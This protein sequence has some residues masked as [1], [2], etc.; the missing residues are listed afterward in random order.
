VSG[1]KVI[2]LSLFARPDHRPGWWDY[3]RKF[4]SSLARAYPVIFPADAGWQV[5]LYHDRNFYHGYYTQAVEL[6]ARGPQKGY[7]KLVYGGEPESLADGM[8]WRLRPVWDADAE[9]VFCRDVDALPT[10]RDRIATEQFLASGLDV[11]T[12]SDN[13]S[14]GVGIL[15]GLCGCRCD[16][17]REIWPSWR[18]LVGEHTPDQHGADQVILRQ[19]IWNR[20]RDRAMGH[21]HVKTTREFGEAV[22]LTGITGEPPDDLPAAVAAEG[23]ALTPCLGA[24]FQHREV[25]EFYDR[26]CPAT[27]E[28]VQQVERFTGQHPV[29]DRQ[30][31]TDRR[32]VFSATLEGDYA[33]YVPLTALLW[34]LVGG[35]TPTALLVGTAAEWTA[36]R[37]LVLGRAREIG[38]EIHWVDHVEGYADA[39]VAQTARLLACQGALTSNYGVPLS[40]DTTLLTADADAWPLSGEYFSRRPEPGEVLSY[41]GNAYH[42]DAEPKV[43][44]C[45]LDATV[46]TWRA[47]VGDR[48]PAELLTAELDPTVEGMAAW[49]FDETWVGA[50]L[51]DRY[52]ERAVILEVIERH[53]CPP[54][55]RV[56]RGGWPANPTAAGMVDAHCLR[57]GHTDENWPRLRPL[58]AEL[59]PGRM[60]WVDDYVAEYRE[61][62]P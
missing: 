36:R 28:P 31:P 7:L 39:T 19:R 3:Y 50:L 42:L 10:P 23:D 25:I 27:S 60:A 8:L 62:T 59:V 46:E 38:C 53:G 45:Y 14:H 11:H 2:G 29:Q 9:Y 4:L 51:A 52:A 15:G 26:E 55:D 58:P 12:I 17:L 22:R 33:F 61:A 20:L 56:D 54:A 6:L 41:Y 57:P 32:A 16:A 43:P 35:R 30:P 24:G 37:P 49:C 5:H 44:I 48:P 40:D 1:A 18:D 21:R 47:V 13:E 34:R